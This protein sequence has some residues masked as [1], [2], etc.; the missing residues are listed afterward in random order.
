MCTGWD[1]CGD[2]GED[3]L[4]ERTT[5]EGL[6]ISKW[7]E[8]DADEEDPALDGVRVIRSIVSRREGKRWVSS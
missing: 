1:G 5:S 3:K 6:G 2:D 4:V 8:P 7:A